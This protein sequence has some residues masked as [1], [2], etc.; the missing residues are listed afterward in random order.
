M[1]VRAFLSIIAILR[2]GTDCAPFIS[3]H[4][5]CRST[6][7]SVQHAQ[8]SVSLFARIHTQTAYQGDRREIPH[9]HACDGFWQPFC[10]NFTT[11]S[12]RS[13]LV[14]DHQYQDIQM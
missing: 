6:H 11:T 3:I 2:D 9:A 10:F 12:H 1:T 5:D 7:P 8:I 4:T 13:S 14:R